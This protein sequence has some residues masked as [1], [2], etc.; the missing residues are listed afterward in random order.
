[1]EESAIGK[2]HVNIFALVWVTYFMQSMVSPDHLLLTACG[3]MAAG[4][5]LGID[6]LN[7]KNKVSDAKISN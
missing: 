4:A 2:Y 5:L 3:M 7:Q 6:R 1:M